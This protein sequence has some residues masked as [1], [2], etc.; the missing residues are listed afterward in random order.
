ME[1]IFFIEKIVLKY[2]LYIKNHFKAVPISKTEA[3]IIPKEEIP[4]ET[5]VSESL[6]KDELSILNMQQ[7]NDQKVTP[8]KK[9]P[10]PIMQKP[11]KSDE[12]LRKL[13]R[14][15]PTDQVGPNSVQ[16]APNSLPSS[17][18]SS[19][20]SSSTTNNS[21]SSNGSIKANMSVRLSNSKATDV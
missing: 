9:K 18:F 20:S 6:K 14:S 11:E 21:S 17:N 4:S 15:P 7:S 19:M 13:G 12:I 3:K 10:P 8:I 16:Q 5:V 2:L 1:L